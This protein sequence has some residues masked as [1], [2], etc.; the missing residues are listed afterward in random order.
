[1]FFFLS[2]IIYLVLFYIMSKEENEL[3]EEIDTRIRMLEIFIKNNSYKRKVIFMLI[4]FIL[5]FLISIIVIYVN[6]NKNK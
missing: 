5:I 6:Y 2:C 3:K 4:S 1:M